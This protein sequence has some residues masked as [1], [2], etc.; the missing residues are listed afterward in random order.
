VRVQPVPATAE[1]PIF[2]VADLP[3]RPLDR[4]DISH[5][6]LH[7]RDRPRATA[8]YRR[9]FGLAVTSEGEA[10]TFL[11][12]SSGFLLALMAD[13][14]PAPPPPWFH[15]GVRL[16]EDGAV[17]ELLARMEEAEV[18]IAKPLYA[19]SALVSFRCRDPDGYAVEVYWSAL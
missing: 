5:L 17:R 2:P 14:A 6:H 9:W 8:F 4:M 18:P 1:L 7:V 13:P 16:P 12:G 11:N 10:I 3:D 15:F 19:D